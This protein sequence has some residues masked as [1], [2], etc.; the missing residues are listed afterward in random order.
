MARVKNHRRRILIAF[1]GW[2]ADHLGGQILTTAFSALA[3]HGWK[4]LMTDQ[5][6]PQALAI[7]PETG[8][9]EVRG[10]DVIRVEATGKAEGRATVSGVGAVA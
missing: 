10:Y 4:S 6:Q 7:R 1:V 9:L 3:V 5:P 8:G 2:T